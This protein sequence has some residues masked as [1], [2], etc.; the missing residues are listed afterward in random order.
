MF[1]SCVGG[2]CLQCFIFK[3]Y[4]DVVTKKLQLSLKVMVSKG[5]YK[6]DASKSEAQNIFLH[7]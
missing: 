1:V 4:V 2:T 5:E 7:L 3:H 6:E